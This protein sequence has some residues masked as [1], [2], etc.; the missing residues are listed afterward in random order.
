MGEPGVLPQRLSR[1]FGEVR[2]DPAVVPRDAVD[3]HPEEPV[4]LPV[5]DG[6]V[7]VDGGVVAH[8]LPQVDGGLREDLSD[9]VEEDVVGDVAADGLQEALGAL[10]G[11]LGRELH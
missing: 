3:E 8:G 5:L 11:G 4:D 9:E 10:D 6:H 2:D 1:S 7:E